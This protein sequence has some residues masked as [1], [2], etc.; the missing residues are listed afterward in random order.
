MVILYVTLADTLRGMDRRAGRHCEE[1]SDAAIA[2]TAP[3]GGSE[4]W[5][6]F[7]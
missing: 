2:M 1:R 3:G 7:V 5:T 4:A 6:F